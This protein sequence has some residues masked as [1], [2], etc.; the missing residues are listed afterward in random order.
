MNLVCN[1]LNSLETRGAETVDGGGG[2]GVGETS[3]ERS[4]ADVVSGLGVLDLAANQSMVQ[5]LYKGIHPH[6]PQAD[7]LNQL[8]VDVGLPDDLGQDLVEHAIEWCVF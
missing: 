2:G 5:D 4:G 3:G 6:I 7:V 1:V 8:R